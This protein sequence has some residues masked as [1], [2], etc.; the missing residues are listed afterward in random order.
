MKGVNTSPMEAGVEGEEEK[1][2][3]IMK[4]MEPLINLKEP[5]L[6]SSVLWVLLSSVPPQVTLPTRKRNCVSKYKEGR[7]QR[8]A[9]TV[10]L[11]LILK[12]SA[13]C[14]D[15]RNCVGSAH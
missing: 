12:F 14:S 4:M 6:P 10:V 15:H 13:T 3:R 8:V 5:W 7:I 2:L 1:F 9:K 11:S